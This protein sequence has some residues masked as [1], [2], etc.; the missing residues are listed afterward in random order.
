[1]VSQR[2]TVRDLMGEFHL[3]EQE[4]KLFSKVPRVGFHLSSNSVLGECYEASNI[5]GYAGAM[6]SAY[7]IGG[8]ERSAETMLNILED[9]Q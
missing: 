2:L 9:A 5:P 8:K 7:K 1:M 4:F 3:P 6:R